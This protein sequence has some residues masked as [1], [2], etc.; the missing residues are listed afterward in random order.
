[1]PTDTD[2]IMH[3]CTTVDGDLVSPD[4]ELSLVVADELV[5][6]LFLGS[7]YFAN[8]FHPFY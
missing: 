7:V 4:L 8:V 1:M 3:V 5:D 2:V 6:D